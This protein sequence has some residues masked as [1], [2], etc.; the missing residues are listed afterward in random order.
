MTSSKKRL[1]AAAL[2]ATLSL[3]LVAPAGAAQAG[4]FQDVGQ[5]SPYYEDITQAGSLG[6]MAGMGGGYFQEESGMTRAMWVTVL[7]K[8][9]GCPQVTSRD[10]FTDVKAEDWFAQAAVWAVDQGI[11]AG[12]EDGSFGVEQVITRQELAVMAEK[13]ADLYR[14]G[15]AA[16]GGLSS[17]ADAGEV[18]DYAVSAMAW[19]MESGVLE[20]VDG[21][22]APQKAV[23]RGDAAGVA[24]RLHRL[25]LEV[26]PELTFDNLGMIM[27]QQIEA[28]KT[29]ATVVPM[30][31]QG[32][33]EQKLVVNGVERTIK[34]YV[35]QDTPQGTMFVLM[36]VPEGQD[37]LTFLYQSGWIEKADAEGFCLYVLEPGPNGWGTPQEELA[38][39]QAAYNEEKSGVYCQ[40]GP[41]M[42]VVGYGE[43]GTNLQKIAMSDPLSVAAGVFLDAS[44]VEG[45]YL[46]QYQT[47]SFDTDTK[48]YGVYYKDTPL[49]VW[50]ASADLS[51]QAMAMVDYWKAANSV[52]D[53]ATQG[54]FGDVFTQAE[55]TDFT[56]EGK[57]LQVAVEEK[58]YDYAASATTDA[59]YDF[60]SQYYR[61]GGG[62][63][64]NMVSKKV[65]YDAL[66]VDFQRFTDSNGIQREYMVY[67][68]TAYR[69]G[70][71]DLPVVVA[72]HG[73]STSMRNFFEN[74]LWYEKAEKEGFIVV[75]PEST[76]VELPSTLNGGLPKAYRPL[77]QSE[78]PDLCYTDVVYTNEL[79]DQLI[80]LYPVDESRIYC[81]GHSMGSM[82]TNYLGSD[83]ISH[84]FAAMGSTS[85]PIVLQEDT[86]TQIVP[87]FLTMAQYDMWSYDLSTDSMVTNAMDMWLIRDG[88]A[89]ENDVDQVRT[90]G[91]DQVYQ[92]GR[93]HNSVW[94]NDAG[95]PL[96]R[97]AW[98]EKKDH[99]NIVDENIL[100]WDQWFSQWQL[101]ENGV[102]SYQGKPIA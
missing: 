67:V 35:P 62:P 87:M 50:I 46:A 49:P 27:E 77:W 51:D 23:T 78:N 71:K 42:Y 47:K 101:G 61:Y 83:E 43:I 1:A 9:A 22:L 29:E 17:Y 45:D 95:I 2:A 11:T 80:K 79:L 88:L 91:A 4:P 100:L 3:S 84:R 39:M 54:Q 59:V 10:T 14:G 25:G 30:L 64:S 40:P 76:L 48:S 99:V 66:G 19:A 81:T 36:N 75:F 70:S 90:Q 44:E 86:G 63:C 94:T 16:Q 68:P 57:I 58:A 15:K 41:S 74:T 72:Y 28:T 98:V 60:L 21:A 33:M 65:D 12:Y 34:L 96:V 85:G 53:T 5:N 69:D 82:M 13:F 73:A 37:T 56:P 97:Y 20:A 102:R 93:Y 31:F 24:V 18:S 38:Y 26:L 92:E 55:D 32:L 89:T 7:Y 8:M 52:G 6:L